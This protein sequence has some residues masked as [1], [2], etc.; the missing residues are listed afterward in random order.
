VNVEQAILA[1]LSKI[2]ELLERQ[3]ST[4]LLTVEEVATKL[5]V[6][7]DLVYRNATEWGAI[8]LPTKDGQRKLVR[9]PAN[10]VE[11]VAESRLN[12]EDP[13][14]SECSLRTETHDGVELLP[15]GGKSRRTT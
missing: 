1:E 7:T 6:S 15:V 12:T 9:F 4:G 2:R 14:T 13:T 5:R 10:V 3:D 8:R 11:R